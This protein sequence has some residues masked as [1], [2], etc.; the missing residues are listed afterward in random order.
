MKKISIIGACFFSL[1]FHSQTFIQAFQDRVN[2]ISSSNINNNLLEFEALGV[3]KTGS[4]ENN[5][6]L[7]WLKNKYLS[8]GYTESQIQEDPFSFNIQGQN[9]NSKNLVVTKTGSLYPNKY[10]IICGHFDTIVGP[11]VNDNGS[12]VSII[13]E[14]ARILKNVPTDYSIRFINFS[15]EEQGLYGSDHYVNSV[16]N[17]TNPKMDI[18]LVFNI[19]Q[20]GGKIGNNNNT[21]YC[22]RDESYP[23]YNNAASAQVTQELANC[24]TLYSPLQTAFDPAYASD[25]VPFQENG[26]VVT[27]FYEYIESGVA[28]TTND[29]YANVDKTY[30]F[31]VA[32]AALGAAQH[33]AGASATLSTNDAV[34]TEQLASLVKFYPNPVKDVLHIEMKNDHQKPFDFELR[35][36][37][38]KVLKKYSNQNVI[39]TSELKP[40]VYMGTVL[41]DNQ[42]IT[43]KIIVK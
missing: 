4:T 34:T 1:A 43:K 14:M 9:R 13:L 3:K 42:K 31:N 17:S 26:E 41:I 32:K 27:G 19:D 38:G 21:I 23:N 5:N 35:D 7:I 8:F 20:V 24:T 37:S 16:V 12:G 28:H 36:A 39:S 11:G 40:G 30:V 29:V 2:L 10:V 15:G 25:Y 22:D 33:F 18:K 6:A